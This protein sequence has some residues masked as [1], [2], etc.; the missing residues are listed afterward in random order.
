MYIYIYHERTIQLIQWIKVDIKC[1]KKT[2]VRFFYDIE[3]EHND[4]LV[5]ERRS[6]SAL[7]MELRLSCT[8]SSMW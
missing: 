4:G 5:Q 7:A 2:L 6:P 8:N 1:W 3:M